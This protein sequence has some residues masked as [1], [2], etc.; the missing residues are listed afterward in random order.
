MTMTYTAIPLLP[1]AEDRLMDALNAVRA[2]LYDVAPG[3]GPISHVAVICLRQNPGTDRCFASTMVNGPRSPAILLTMISE[4]ARAF[5]AEVDVGSM[6]V[7]YGDDVPQD[8][9]H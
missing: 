4:I 8:R 9:R 5:G 3:D 6:A 1:D 7:A 2:A